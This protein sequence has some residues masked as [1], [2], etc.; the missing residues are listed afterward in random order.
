V[1]GEFH[2]LN[3]KIVPNGR[4][5]TFEQNTHFANLQSNLQPVLKDIARTCR[6]NSARRQW[7]RRFDGSEAE[8][9]EDLKLLES[10]SLSKRQSSRLG[11]S[12]DERVIELEQLVERNAYDFMQ[13][14]AP[15]VNALR[16]DVDSIQDRQIA[17]DDPLSVVP[18]TKRLAFQEVLELIYANSQNKPVANSMVSKIVKQLAA[19]YGAK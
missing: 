18:Y 5:D 14:L 10:G 16:K 17:D 19:K 7:E 12:M 11:R 6:Q 3:R 2:I 13:E 15:R 4:R 9:R 1:V 8:L